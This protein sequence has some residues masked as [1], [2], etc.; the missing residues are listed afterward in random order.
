MNIQEFVTLFSE[1]FDDTPSEKFTP[2]TIFKE[3]GEWDSLAALSILAMVDEELDI[4]ISGAD[5]R[6]SDTIT[7]LFNLI[8]SK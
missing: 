6:N 2:S 3:L 1:Q 8:Q 4:R 5:I 7:D